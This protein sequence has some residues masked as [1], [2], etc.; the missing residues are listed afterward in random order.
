MFPV[1]QRKTREAPDN[2]ADKPNVDKSSDNGNIKADK[3]V[4]EL[5][6]KKMVDKPVDQKKDQAEEKPKPTEEAK[7]AEEIEFQVRQCLCVCLCL[8]DL[9]MKSV[10]NLYLLLAEEDQPDDFGFGQS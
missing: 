1:G 4:D 3:T 7:K 9:F 8:C 5:G 10:S 6:Q 2:P